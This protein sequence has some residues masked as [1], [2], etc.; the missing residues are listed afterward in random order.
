MS[1]PLI[2]FVILPSTIIK[3]TKVSLP[4]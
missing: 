3:M 1:I 4:T 2:L